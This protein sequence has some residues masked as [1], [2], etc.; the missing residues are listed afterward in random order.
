MNRQ[1]DRDSVSFNLEIERTFQA[2]RMEQQGLVGLEEMA[3][4]RVVNNGQ[5]GN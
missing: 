4:E 5:N 1:Q 3:E 2:K